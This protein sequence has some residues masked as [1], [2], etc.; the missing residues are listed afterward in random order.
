[1]AAAAVPADQT[2]LAAAGFR[3]GT[4][5]VLARKW[6]PLPYKVCC[7]KLGRSIIRWKQRHRD[8][9]RVAN[10]YTGNCF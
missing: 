9:A 6:Q 10:E 3:V 2:A 7:Y 5:A 4:S 8:R 1:L